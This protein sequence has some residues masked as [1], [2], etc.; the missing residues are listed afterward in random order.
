M[1]DDDGHHDGNFES[2]TMALMAM[3]TITPYCR[4]RRRSHLPRPT[5]PGGVPSVALARTLRVGRGRGIGRRGGA[6]PHAPL[7]RPI[8]GAPASG[9]GAEPRGAADGE[10]AEEGAGARARGQVRSGISIKREP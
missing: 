10:G 3:V 1:G 4:L 5:N 7:P 2:L 8:R 6:F 9:A